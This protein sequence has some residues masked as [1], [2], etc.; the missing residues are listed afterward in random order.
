MIINFYPESDKPELKKATEEYSR[1]WNADGQKIVKVIEKISGLKFKEKEIN[2]LVFNGVSYSIP[3]QLNSNQTPDNKRGA[4]TH[5]LCHR[6]IVGNNLKFDFKYEDE[7]WNQEVHKQV[8][9]ILYD[10]WV[11]LYG[12]EFADDQVEAEGN[13]LKQEGI[14]PFKVAWN[15]ALSLTK[16]ERAKE[17]KSLINESNL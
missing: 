1:I 2:A 12:K 15:W 13:L 6:L 17:F 7:N 5:E 8:D 16:E 4:L 10:I 3:L 9:L 14:S 11:D